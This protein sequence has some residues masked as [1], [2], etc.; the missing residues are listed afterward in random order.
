M[1]RQLGLDN[2]I[3]V[4]SVDS[5][6]GVTSSFVHVVRARRHVDTPDQYFGIQGEK[7]REYIC[8][9][10]GK[11]ATT[12]WLEEEPHGVPGGMKTWPRGDVLN[13]GK[14]TAFGRNKTIIETPF[15]QWRVFKQ[16]WDLLSTSG[17]N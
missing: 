17:K 12:M 6:R 5:I 11:V 7:K 3:K 8:Y 10:C 9:T 13:R 2:P 1:F 15:C 16:N 4:L 14:L